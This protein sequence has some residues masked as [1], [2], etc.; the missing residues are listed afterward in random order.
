M[1][2]HRRAQWLVQSMG[3]TPQHSSSSTSKGRPP[4][5]AVGREMIARAHAA[6]GQRRIGVSRSWPALLDQWPHHAV[7][8]EWESTRSGCTAVQGECNEDE[9]GEDQIVEQHVAR[10]TESL[11]EATD[12]FE[13]EA[14][15]ER[16]KT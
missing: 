5:A 11:A 8:C 2:M 4:V 15:H 10:S 9:S 14:D 7:W 12:S 16:K 13:N 3:G 1:P 6:R